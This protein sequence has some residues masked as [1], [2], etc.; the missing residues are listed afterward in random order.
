MKKQTQN[1]KGFSPLGAIIVI[2]L[3]VGVLALVLSVQNKNT[4][5]TTET[6]NVVQS[7]PAIQNANDL[8]AVSAELDKSDLGAFDKE[9][10]QLDAD[11]S[12]F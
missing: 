2:G 12:T 9:L 11:T 10:N 3:V 4:R 8:T 1:Q 5:T 6:Q 7:V